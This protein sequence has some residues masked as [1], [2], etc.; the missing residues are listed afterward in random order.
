MAGLLWR[1]IPWRAVWAV[2]AWLVREGRNRLEQNLS[3]SDR[4]R[5]WT[6]MRK[7]KGRPLRNLTPKERQDLTRLARQAARGRS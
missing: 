1:R 5:F 4:E 7:A 6:L 2:S 3:P